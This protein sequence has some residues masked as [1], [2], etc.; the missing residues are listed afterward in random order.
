MLLNLALLFQAGL[1]NNS[2]SKL[3]SKLTEERCNN[4]NLFSVAQL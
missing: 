3:T 1:T 2:H 4:P